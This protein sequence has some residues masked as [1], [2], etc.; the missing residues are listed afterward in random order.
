MKKEMVSRKFFLVLAGIFLISLALAAPTVSFSSSTGESGQAKT[1]N[2]SIAADINNITEVKIEFYSLNITSSS[3]SSD[4]GVAPVQSGTLFT[5]SASSLINSS[6][7]SYFWFNAMQYQEATFSINVTT[8]DNASV[9]T[10]ANKTITISDTVN[11]VTTFVSP[12]PP[13]DEILDYDFIELNVSVDES[14]SGVKNVTFYL[15]NSTGLVSSQTDTAVPFIHNFTGLDDGTYD[16]NASAFDNAS[17]L[18]FTPTRTIQI[19]TGSGCLP[20]WTCSWTACVNGTQTQTSCTDANSCGFIAPAATQA[21]ASCTSNWDCGAWTPADC[22][23]NETQTSV[24]TD[25]NNCSVAPDIKT[26]T[27][28]SSGPTQL[29]GLGLSALSPTTI[30]FIIL[31][32]IIASVVVVFFVLIRLKKKSQASNGS[33]SSYPAYSPRGPPPSPPGMPPALPPPSYAN[34]PNAY[35]N[36]PAY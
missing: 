32:V 14:G 17:N 30:F 29:G 20:N 15:H 28:V 31:G 21:C 19:T 24:C 27:C 5:F 18:D 2:L 25:L 33:D 13:D 10:S 23:G 16:I 6:L 26:R 1:Y 11:P 7:A 36:P 3:V 34:P 8:T 35:Q 22:A 12:T 4:T 9:V